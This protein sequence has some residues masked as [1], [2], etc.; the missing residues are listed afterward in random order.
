ML[1]ASMSDFDFERYWQTKLTKNIEAKVSEEIAKEVLEGNELL[2]DKTTREEIFEW[3]NLALDK[4]E[5]VVSQDDLHE[6]MLACACHYPKDDLQVY[7][8]LLEETSDLDLVLAE[9]E[10]KFSSFLKN[11]L[12]LDEKY[13]NLIKGH[14]MG[15]AGERTEKNTIIATKIPKSSYVKDYFDSEDPNV[16]RALYCHCP[17]I[18]D[19]LQDPKKTLPEAYCYCGAGFYQNIWEEITGK[20]VKVEILETVIHGGDVC[21][22]A[23]HLSE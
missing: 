15:F 18:R 22:I 8:K 1:C 13:I 10:K 12:Q 16:K 14:K 3:S 19:M 9:M 20:P 11:V 2:S 7:K 6:I 17:R 23:I 21:K 5:K 4:L